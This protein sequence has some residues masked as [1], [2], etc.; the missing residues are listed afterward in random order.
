MF[1]DLDHAPQL[2]AAQG[3]RSVDL[4][5]DGIVDVVVPE[6]PDA[7]DEPIQFT[8]RLSAVI[9]DELSSLRSVPGRE[10][11]QSRLQRY[12]RIGL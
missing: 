10:R 5:R 11:L 9:A 12:R 1:R 7:A 6:R 2:A 4:L 3:I 8:K